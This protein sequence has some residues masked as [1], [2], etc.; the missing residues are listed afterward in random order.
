MGLMPYKDPEK[1]KETLKNYYKKNKDKLN[2][3]KKEWCEKNKE[4]YIKYHQEY[5]EKNREIIRERVRLYNSKNKDKKNEYMKEYWKNNK[6]E[7]SERHKKWCEK[8][9]YR[10]DKLYPYRKILN[11]ESRCELCGTNQKLIVHHIDKNRQNNDRN[12]LRIFCWSCHTKFHN[13]EK[14][15]KPLEIAMGR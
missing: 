3:M 14:S 6:N 8:N 10:L 5:R 11:T 7:I 1:R 13:S 12:N 9:Q 2:K 15:G 4:S